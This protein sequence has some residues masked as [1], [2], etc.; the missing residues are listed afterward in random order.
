MQVKCRELRSPGTVLKGITETINLFRCCDWLSKPKL[1]ANL[2]AGRRFPIRTEDEAILGFSKV[3]F[4]L[5][6]S[7]FSVNE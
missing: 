2:S 3:S 7:A 5:E 4:N 6:V 1:T